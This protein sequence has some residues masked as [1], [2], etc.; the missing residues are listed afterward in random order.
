MSCF[1]PNSYE[2]NEQYKFSGARTVESLTALALKMLEPVIKDLS[3][4]K[5]NEFNISNFLNQEKC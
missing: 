1:I 4:D 3:Q 5:F 2:N